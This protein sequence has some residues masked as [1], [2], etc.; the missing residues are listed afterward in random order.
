MFLVL[1]EETGLVTLFRCPSGF[2]NKVSIEYILPF[3]KSDILAC[4]LHLPEFVK[5]RKI[6]L[7][8]NEWRSLIK[9]IKNGTSDIQLS[10]EALDSINLQNSKPLKVNTAFLDILKDFTT[11]S[12]KK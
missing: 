7:V 1:F 12:F 5:P 10:Q 11:W 6:S 3:E 4:G 2:T 8:N 9:P